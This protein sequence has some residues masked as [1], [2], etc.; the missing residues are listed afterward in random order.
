MIGTTN[1]TAIDVEDVPG[2]R[3]E[4]SEE[5]GVDIQD[6]PTVEDDA[7]DAGSLFVSEDEMPGRSKRPR[8][9][10]DLESDSESAVESRA[11]SKRRKD[12]SSDEELV[13]A[14]DKKKLAMNTTYEGFSIY[15]RVL[16]LI[17]KRKDRKGKNTPLVGGQAMIQDWITSTQMPPQEDD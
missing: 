3:R 5:N 7:S 13:G 17:V 12:D 2:I 14:D 1:E 6:I 8:A 4:E 15:G 9:R 16:C 10:I 11:R